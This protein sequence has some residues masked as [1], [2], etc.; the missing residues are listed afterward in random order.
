[1]QVQTDNM[2]KEILKKLLNIYEIEYLSFRDFCKK[3][4]KKSFW[5]S[6]PCSWDLPCKESDTITEIKNNKYFRFKIQKGFI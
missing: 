5:F 3:K 1:M 6:Q 4:F 2:N